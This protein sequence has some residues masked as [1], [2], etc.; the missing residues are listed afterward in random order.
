VYG[1]CVAS[2]GKKLDRGKSFHSKL[3][4]KLRVGISINSSNFDQVVELGSSLFV[5]R[6]KLLAVPAPWRVELHEDGLGGV[7]GDRVKSSI[8]EFQH[9]GGRLP[10]ATRGADL[11]VHPRHDGVRS[12]SPIVFLRTAGRPLGEVL[13]G[14]VSLHVV[15]GGDVHGLRGVHCGDDNAICFGEC[16]TCNG[17]FWSQILAMPAPWGV[18]LHEGSSASVDG[19]VEVR[20]REVKDSP[21]G[22]ANRSEDV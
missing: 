19:R 14:G 8:S 17:P 18:E 20:T 7:E 13:D 2:P 4:C 21:K 9:G 16:I 22:R 5:Q 12:S 15:A 11:V 6:S 10:H 3:S 1:L